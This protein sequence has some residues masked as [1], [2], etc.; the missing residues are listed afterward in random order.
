MNSTQ[1]GEFVYLRDILI[2]DILRK[3]ALTLN[4]LLNTN[5]SSNEFQTSEPYLYIHIH[6]QAIQLTEPRLM[7]DYLRLKDRY[8]PD[9][10]LIF[11]T[12]KG[13]RLRPAKFRKRFGKLLEEAG[14]HIQT[15][16]PKDITDSQYNI[17]LELRF[18][19]QR[20]RYQIALFIAL[21]AFLATRPG[22]TAN[23]RKSD[24][25][26]EALTLRLPDTKS[27]RTQWLPIPKQLVPFLKAYV[28]HLR[29]NNAPLFVNSKGKQW[30]RREAWRKIKAK[31]E[32]L[33]IYGVTPQRLRPTA[34]RG[35][36]NNGAS[37][38]TVSKLLRH[39]DPKTTRDHYLFYADEDM[40][41]VIDDYHP[42]GL[43]E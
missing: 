2:I 7:R 27:G 6:G 22:E 12:A 23:L 24:L 25:D 30:D 34:A 17:L 26:F 8:L 28:S 1:C 35:W 10:D 14:L 3:S 41:S 4:Q 37:L 29:S 21:Q 9:S 32:E 18:P 40:R 38:T 13:S 20:H 5:A 15:P 42:G 33:N 36:K 39:A 11:P 31:A 16:D 43:D 19:I